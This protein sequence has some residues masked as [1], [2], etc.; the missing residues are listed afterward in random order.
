MVVSS[1]LDSS[2][3]I[4]FTLLH[5]RSFGDKSLGRVDIGMERLLELQRLQPNEGEYRLTIERDATVDNWVNLDVVLSL[6]DMKGNP[7]P[8]RLSVRVTQDSTS[9]VAGGA[10]EQAKRLHKSY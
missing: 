7:S 4:V 6:V 2:L 8:A 5:N 10:V 1:S 3:T 9:A